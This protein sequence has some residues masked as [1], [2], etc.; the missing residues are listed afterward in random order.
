MVAERAI[1]FSHNLWALLFPV[2]H[3][4]MIVSM[5]RSKQGLSCTSM[6]TCP[7]ARSHF[8]SV[9]NGQKSTRMGAVLSQGPIIRRRRASPRWKRYSNMSLSPHFLPPSSPS[10]LFSS[11]GFHRSCCQ[12]A[13]TEG[14]EV[15]AGVDRRV[16]VRK[17][18][19]NEGFDEPT[20]HKPLHAC[21]YARMSCLTLPPLPPP[22]HARARKH[23]HK[24]TNILK[25]KQRKQT[26]TYMQRL[27]LHTRK[28]TRNL[29]HYIAAIETNTCTQR[30]HPTRHFLAPYYAH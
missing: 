24:L 6:Q 11:T 19:K 1:E 10:I 20:D 4:T 22:V 15:G 18:V 25:I 14:G 28:H 12:Q 27:C 26:Y 2:A 7:H 5:A 3:C 30:T 16:F 8:L 23:N 17:C 21:E 29:L 13:E 9:F